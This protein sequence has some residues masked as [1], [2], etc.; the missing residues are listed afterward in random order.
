[1]NKKQ[2]NKKNQRSLSG[3]IIIS[4][5]IFITFSLGFFPLVIYA[6]IVL[7]FFSFN[8]IWHLFILPFLLLLGFNIFLFYQLLFSGLI[9]HVFKIKYYPGKYQYSYKEKNAFNWILFCL[10]YTFGRRLLE[11]YPMGSMKYT[12]FRLLGMKI[13]KNTLVGGTVQDPCLTEF[14]NNVTM[15]LYSVIY[16]HIH[17]YEKGIISMDK[18]IIGNN[19]VIG[20]GA[21]IMPGA[22]VQ[23]NVKI[24]AGS[25]VTKGQVLEKGKIYGGIPAKEIK[26][27]KIV[28]KEV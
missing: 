3:Y 13:G 6:K 4:I 15:G 17:D 25:I 21:Y 11:I 28:K 7:L 23:D 18:V 26:I 24:A 8:Q 12:Y 10:L 22:V 1:M 16:G 14:G 19:V 20:A 9:I 2:E 27:K 5:I